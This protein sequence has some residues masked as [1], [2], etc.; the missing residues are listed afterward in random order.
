L[1]NFKFF[2]SRIFTNRSLCFF[3][4]LLPVLV[5]ASC[6]SSPGASSYPGD[7]GSPDFSLLPPEAQV[8]LWADVKQG[9][10]LL[11]ALSFQGLDGSNARDVLDRTGYAAAAFYPKQAAQRFFLAG[12]GSYPST[13]AGI[14]MAFSRDW[15]TSKS[16]TGKKFWFSKSWG[17]GI[18]MGAKLALAADKDPF[19]PGGAY[20]PEGFEEFRKSCALA[21]W[22]PE[23]EE[24]LNR[25]LQ[26]M[27]IPI[28][29]PAEDFFFG[30]VRAGGE[31]DRWELISRIR[32]PSPSQARALVTLFTMARMFIGDATGG[33]GLTGALPLLF[34][35]IP[36]QDGADISLYSGVMDTKEIALLFNSFSVYSSK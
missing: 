10:P 28:K 32:T 30:V 2:L 13:R 34:A 31:D 33:D 35:N 23:P 15:K 25:F 8:Y 1:K 6:A 4:T 21:G 36:V 26:V 12:W 16:E 14:S 19:A 11:D 20:C 18:A 7:D 24:P 9:R 22:M 29:I 5:L 27:N 17:L 3:F